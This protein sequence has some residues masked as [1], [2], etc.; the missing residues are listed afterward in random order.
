MTT[1]QPRRTVSAAG[2][3]ALGV[4]LAPALA[5][6]DLLSLTGPLGAGKTCF[7]TG[8]ARGLFCGARVRSPT[9][10]LVHEYP[11]RILLVHADLYRVEEGDIDSL[12]LADYADRAVLAVEWGERL[13]RPWRARAMRI[14]FEIGSGDERRLTASAQDARG[15]ELVAAW[16]AL[17]RPVTAEGA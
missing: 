13:P 8:L 10:A 6:G 12:G 1:S 17:E 9:Y 11:G 7:V 15:R 4:A 16:D 3:E 2:T 5:A 14:A